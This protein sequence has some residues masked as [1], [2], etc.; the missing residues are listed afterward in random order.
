MVSIH[1]IQKRRNRDASWFLGCKKILD[2]EV[3][4]WAESASAEMNSL[5]KSSILDSQMANRIS[6]RF[7]SE[8]ARSDRLVLKVLFCPFPGVKA[9]TKSRLPMSVA[10]RLVGISGDPV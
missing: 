4:G 3:C 1:S 8:M 7:Q 10:E 6:R 9:R 5:A 2:A